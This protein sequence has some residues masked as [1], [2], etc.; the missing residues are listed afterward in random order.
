MNRPNE[1]PWGYPLVW[2][3]TYLAEED[4]NQV[5]A[6]IRPL[7]MS[8]E[9]KMQKAKELR[10]A[11]WSFPRIANYLGE[12]KTTIFNWIHDYPYSKHIR[13]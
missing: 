8:G 7:F 10:Q 3:N 5:A 4:L 6:Q 11:R 9:E 2:T 1:D 12:S 13:L